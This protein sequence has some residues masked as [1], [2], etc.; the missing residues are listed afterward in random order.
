MESTIPQD[1]QEGG[2]TPAKA[3]EIVTW[4]GRGSVGFLLA[5]Q[6][7]MAANIPHLRRRIRE[8]NGDPEHPECGCLWSL[9]M[10]LQAAERHEP[11]ASCGGLIAVRFFYPRTQPR[12]SEALGALATGRRSGAHLAARVVRP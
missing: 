9:Q 5:F 8:I 11:P 4:A 6:A 10:Q 1:P 12:P 2:L 3:E 7:Q